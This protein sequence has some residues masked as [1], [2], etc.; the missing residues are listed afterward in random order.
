MVMSTL[1]SVKPWLSAALRRRSGNTLLLGKNPV[2]EER[3]ARS[4]QL[5]PTRFSL[6]ATNERLARWVQR[7]VDTIGELIIQAYGLS[8]DHLAPGKIGD[9]RAAFSPTLSTDSRCGDCLS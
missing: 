2:N 4:N 5:T 6:K 9:E 8:P 3:L 7:G 1:R